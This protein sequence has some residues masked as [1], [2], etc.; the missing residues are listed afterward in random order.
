M[1]MTANCDP[2]Y[3]S[4]AVDVYNTETG[5]V[6]VHDA[7]K[8][9]ELVRVGKITVLGFTGEKYGDKNYFFYNLAKSYLV[10]ID[11]G[12]RA[13]V[14]KEILELSVKRPARCELVYGGNVLPLKSYNGRIILD[15]STWLESK[16]MLV[17]CGIFK[18]SA[19]GFEGKDY[20]SV[21]EAIKAARAV[22]PS[23]IS[24]TEH[25]NRLREMNAT[26]IEFRDK[27]RVL[28]KYN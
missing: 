9:N 18:F 27:V 4:Y 5:K 19:C 1:L 10:G 20:P 15:P 25:V 26:N 13:N 12:E 28:A 2:K 17:K 8:L 16:D 14:W 24:I 11:Q 7:F 6:T 21:E 3:H 23:L 22:H